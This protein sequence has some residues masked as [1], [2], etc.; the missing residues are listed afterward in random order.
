MKV[1]PY[2]RSASCTTTTQK[3][4][5]RQTDAEVTDRKST[6]VDICSDDSIIVLSE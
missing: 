1:A 2:D 5:V 6:L 3:R 4:L